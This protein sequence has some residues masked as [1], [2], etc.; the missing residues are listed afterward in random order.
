MEMQRGSP[1]YIAFRP[2]Q[3]HFR[4]FGQLT[5]KNRSRCTPAMLA[6]TLPVSDVARKGKSKEK[7]FGMT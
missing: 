1:E 3:C 4:G 6:T 2:K 7:K 5:S